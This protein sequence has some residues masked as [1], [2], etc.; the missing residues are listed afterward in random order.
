MASL[1]L[2]VVGAAVGSAISPG[3][4]TYWGFAAGSAIGG[5]LDSQ[6]IFPALFSK[7]VT[8]FGP[9]LTDQMVQSGSEGSPMRWPIGPLNR[10]AGTVIW[11]DDQ[12]I[13]EQHTT[14]TEGGKGSPSVKSTTYSYFHHFAIGVA[15]AKDISYRAVRKIY[16]GSKLIYDNGPT[17]YY[18][19]IRIYLG[20]QT[21]ADP[22]IA[23]KKTAKGQT[24]SCFKKTLYIVFEKFALADFNGQIPNITVVVEQ[25]P[26]C[27]ARQ[28]IEL[29]CARAGYAFGE[30]DA[31]LVPYCM[32]GYTLSGPTASLEALNT[33]ALMYGIGARETGGQ[34]QFYAKGSELVVPVDVN[35]MVA[36]EESEDPSTRPFQ[37]TKPSTFELPKQVNLRFVDSTNDLQQGATRE[38]KQFDQGPDVSSVEVTITMAP[39]EA[40]AI[41]KRI[42]WTADAEKTKFALRLPPSYIELQEGDVLTWTYNNY[43]YYGVVEDITRGNNFIHEVTGR[44]VQQH[45]YTQK[46]SFTPYGGQVAQA[47]SP[48]ATTGL[49]MDIPALVQEQL[50]SIGF[51]VAMCASAQASLWKG[52]VVMRNRPPSTAYS[53]AAQLPQE[54]IMG[55]LNNALQYAPPTLWDEVNTIDVTMTNGILNNATEDEVYAG[56]N[57][58]AVQTTTGWEIIAFRTATSIGTNRYRLSGLLRGRRG[59]DWASLSP[60]FANAAFVL[61][62][63]DT[64]IG[65]LDVGTAGLG[66]T[67]NYKF[68]A[69]QGELS[70]YAA[71]SA[72]CL[73]GTMR[74]MAPVNVIVEDDGS[75]GANISWTR[76]SKAL[77][78]LLGKNG[79]TPDETPETYRIYFYK[80]PGPN[81]VYLRRVVDVVASTTFNYTSTMWTED[82]GSTGWPPSIRLCQVSQVVGDGWPVDV[83]INL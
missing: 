68:P 26:N 42:L 9:R 1:V 28:A 73:G 65:W 41:A 48:P 51:T 52:G 25:N 39:D 67:N 6:F 40:K 76:R 37:L 62:K 70:A 7:T 18:S 11:M 57:H 75:S 82:M 53:L 4:G 46:A 49:I 29:I 12:R 15:D 61:L 19:G 33:L 3:A 56:A 64:S 78:W 16:A 77:D 31:S 43:V 79:L 17:N 2:G 69:D 45:I 21:T 44:L 23:A 8:S 80:S 74:P 63:A 36:H 81:P 20:T 5:I 30:Y 38:I 13:E 34:L 22:L 60:L 54:A 35:Q 27:S 24:A 83:F 59:T 14:T 10:L 47:Y 55:I 71:Q 32:K 72:T 50:S 66:A 58:A